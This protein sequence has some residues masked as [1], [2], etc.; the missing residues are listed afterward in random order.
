METAWI[1][2]QTNIIPPNEK[3]KMCGK[4]MLCGF[5]YNLAH[6]IRCSNFEMSEKVLFGW[7]QEKQI[8]SR[9]IEKL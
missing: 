2:A 1:Q 5:W 8:L 3:Y 4:K 7:H 6:G 9:N